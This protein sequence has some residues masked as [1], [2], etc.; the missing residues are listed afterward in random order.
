M[1]REIKYAHPRKMTSKPGAI[2]PC[3]FAIRRAEGVAEPRLILGDTGGEPIASD[4]I[5]NEQ[6]RVVAGDRWR[7]IE[8]ILDLEVSVRLGRDS[9]RV[10][11]NVSTEECGE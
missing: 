10:V 5:P 8:R 7:R 1:D 11:G 9:A 3:R 4:S 2:L 6:H